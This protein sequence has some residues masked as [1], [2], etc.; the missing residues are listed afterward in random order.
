MAKRKPERKPRRKRK[1][2]GPPVVHAPPGTLTTEPDAHPATVHVLAYGPDGLEELRACDRAKLHELRSRFP[3][4][5]V[6]VIGLGDAELITAFGEE[7]GLHALA[8]EDVVHTHQRPKVQR[9]G[10]VTQVI[11][12]IVEDLASSETEQLSVFVG[13]GFVLSFEERR[14]DIF[15]VVR[16]RIRDRAQRLCDAKSDFLA[17]TLLDVA[18]DA[19]YPVLETISEELENVEDAIPEAKPLELTSRLRHVKHQLLGMR[20]ALWPMREVLGA[21]AGDESPVIKEETRMYFRDCQD[22]CAQLIDIVTTNR[23]LATDLVDLQLSVAGQRLNEVMKVL[24]AMATVFIPLTFICS[25]Y[26]M[27]FNTEK[28][29]LN[30]PELNW[31]WGYPFALALMIATAAGLLVYFRRRDWV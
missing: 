22:H 29:P 16:Q 3:V 15:E 12:R 30:M 25:V 18:V 4:T 13:Q 2:V 17:Y 26:G 20:R 19:F 21:L 28:S 5:W 10:D 9:F 7:F 14:E 23:E 1:R 27:N 8:L 11:V 31:Y 6:H 24:T